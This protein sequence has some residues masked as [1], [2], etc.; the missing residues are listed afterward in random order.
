M[1]QILDVPLV[2]GL[3]NV[4]SLSI[5]TGPAAILDQSILEMTSDSGV[6]FQ[7]MECGQA[8]ITSQSDEEHRNAEYRIEVPDETDE[9]KMSPR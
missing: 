7:A 2:A 4:V 5:T 9:Q 8:V 3:T 1:F 6:L